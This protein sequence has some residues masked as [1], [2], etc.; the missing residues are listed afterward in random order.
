MHIRKPCRL[1]H[2]PWIVGIHPEGD[3]FLYGVG[4]QEIVLG[5]IG[6]GRPQVT[7][8]YIVHVM[9]VD[10]QRT[11]RDIVGAQD[12]I[13]KR[14]LAGTGLSHQSHIFPRPDSKG[15]VFQ[16]IQFPVGIVEC[17]VPELNVPPHI[18]QAPGAL[19]VR[20]VNLRVQQLPQTVQ[21][22]LPPGSHVYELG[23]RHDRPD[24][25]IEITDELHQL[26]G[27]ELVFIHKISPVAKNHA[28][29]AFHEHGHHDPQQ[30]GR[31]SVV[32]IGLLILLVQLLKGH[33]L[34]GLL[35]EGLYHR[36]A[37]K[38]LLGEIG[39]PGKS[40]LTDIPLFH[41]LLPDHRGRPQQKRHGNQ[42]Q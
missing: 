40:L 14:R 8:F 30:H 18:L 12:Q 28:D 35:D 39:K 20:H 23:H 15:Y 19:P 10:E 36:N 29:H 16:H 5:Y 25:G 17:Q 7:D 13:H 1:G 6:A 24:D 38:A 32:N 2:S 22:R 41:H 4:E 11:V 3:I 42:G 21:G 34:P 31:L 37:G 9:A 27:I 33:Q 26:A